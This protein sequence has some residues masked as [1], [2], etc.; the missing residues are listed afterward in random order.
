[1]LGLKPGFLHA[2]EV[3]SPLFHISLLVF[4]AI[5]RHVCQK[6]L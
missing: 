3:L 6:R 4:A 2:G 5:G 1:M